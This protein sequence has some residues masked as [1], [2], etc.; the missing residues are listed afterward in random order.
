MPQAKPVAPPPKNPSIIETID[1]MVK[2][3][4]SEE[5]ILNTL[6]DI[7]I[8]PDNARRLLILGQADV[9]SLLKGEIMR[10]IK[11]ELEREEPELKKITRDETASAI[12]EAKQQLAKTVMAEVKE[13][14]KT[15]AG[16]NKLFEDQLNEKIQKINEQEE[17]TFKKVGQVGEVI[18]KVQAD[19]NEVGIKGVG[20]R[21]KFIGHM[22]VALGVIFGLA[23]LYMLYTTLQQPVQTYSLIVIAI[24]AILTV[25]LLVVGTLI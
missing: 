1:K 18:N 21:N 4:E 3:G 10:T 25:T 12:T 17:K 5:K 8:S 9:F 16:Q 19:M 7:G 2:E 23:T 14:E 11:L 22:V 20:G 15:L 24:M 13:Y 6:K